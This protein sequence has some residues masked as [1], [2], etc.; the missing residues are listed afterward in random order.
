MDSFGVPGE[1]G[2]ALLHEWPTISDREES[3]GEASP[4]LSCD[5]AVDYR[6]NWDHMSGEQL[7][8]SSKEETFESAADGEFI[9]DDAGT[10]HLAAAGTTAPALLVQPDAIDMLGALF[11]D[12]EVIDVC[13]LRRDM[14]G[15]GRAPSLTR[16]QTAS[17]TRCPGRGIHRR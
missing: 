6:S 11:V 12:D 13:S 17:R 10:V 16:Q 1:S 15:V 4:A 3:S 9:D 2:A 14:G 7:Q 8:S 5:V